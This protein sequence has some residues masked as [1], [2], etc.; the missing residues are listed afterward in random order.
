[1]LAPE[2][3]HVHYN[4][5]YSVSKTLANSSDKVSLEGSSSQLFGF[6]FRHRFTACLH[7]KPVKTLMNG[8]LIYPLA[9][10]LE[11]NCVMK[12]KQILQISMSKL[13]KNVHCEGLDKVLDH[14]FLN[15]IYIWEVEG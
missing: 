7:S 15:C 5:R 11:V 13:Q 8:R 10:K 4:Y 14:C 12:H 9:N 2:T 1:M 6:S 3:L